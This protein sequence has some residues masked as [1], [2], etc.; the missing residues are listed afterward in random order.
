MRHPT[1]DQWYEDPDEVI[2]YAQAL[3]DSGRLV[4]MGEVADYLAT[5]QDWTEGH[6]VWVRHGRP[7]R[8]DEPSRVGYSSA[9][10]TAATRSRSRYGP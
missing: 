1:A 3:L 9:N 2:L 4:E 6:E 8:R 5:P 10:G 7:S